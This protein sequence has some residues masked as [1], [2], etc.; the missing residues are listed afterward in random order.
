LKKFIPVGDTLVQ[1]TTVNL[2]SALDDDLKPLIE[3]YKATFQTDFKTIVFDHIE[4]ADYNMLRFYIKSNEDF[5]D[6]ES[7]RKRCIHA[8]LK[9]GIFS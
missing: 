1:V 6:V 8:A 4:K 3:S 7:L 9:N 5:A 2:V